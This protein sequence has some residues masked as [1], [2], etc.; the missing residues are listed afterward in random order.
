VDWDEPVDQE[1]H[2]KWHHIATDIQEVTTYVYPRPYFTQHTYPVT[3][4]QIH[5]FADASL[6]AYGAVA[7]L[8]H[9]DQPTIVMSR[10][11][12]APVKSITLPK[13]E[14]MAAVI[15]TRLTKF[16]I[17]SLHLTPDDTTVHLWSDSQITLHWIYNIKQTSTT[18]PFVSNRVTE[19]TQSFPASTWTYVP[20]D[21]N[22]ADLL[23]R[24]ISAQQL[25]SSQLWLHGPSWLTSADQWP[26]WS[27]ANVLHLQNTDVD[28]T[29]D[30][31]NRPNNP[32]ET[33][34][35]HLVIDATRHSRLTKLLSITVYVL[36]FGHNL[37]HPQGKLT[38]PITA[39]ELSDSRMIWIKTSQ[40]LEYFDEI[41]NLKSQSHKRT[42][43]VRQLRLF[44]DDREFLRCGGR[45]HNAP[46]SELAKFPYLLSPNH[47]ITKLIVYATHERIHHSGVSSTVTA[48]RQ[49]YWFPAIRVFV[50]KLL[51]RCVT[52]VRLTG[53]PYRLP[54]PP[55]LP[56]TRTEDPTP[57]SVCGVDFTGAMYV[58][59]GE[60]ERKVYI[61]LFTCATTR[62]VHLEV[63]LDMTVESFMLAFRKFVGRRSLPRT[64]MSDNASTYLAAA[65]ELQ[66]LL[67]ST[68][69][70][71]ALEGHGITWQFIP[72]RAPWH[73]GFWERL[74][75]IT[76]QAL[77]K[78][79]GRSFVTLQILE[80]IVV[81]VEAT[82]NDRPLTYVSSDVADVEP[83]TPAHLLY[84]KRMTTLPH[85]YDEDPDDPDYVVSESRMR[86]Q[87]TNHARLLQHFQTRWKREYLTSLREFHK[88]SGMNIQNVQIGDVVLIHDDGPRL[89]WRLGVIDSLI[90]GNDGFVRSA[91]VR[92]SNRVTSRPISRL[93]PLEISHPPTDHDNSK[94]D[95][96]TEPVIH[97][98]DSEISNRPRRE[99]A[100]KARTRLL[101]WTAQLSAPP[102]DVEN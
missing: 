101:E 15:A 32:T 11:R 96:L 58:R 35:I 76:K 53:K 51:R 43:L 34:G 90:Q 44:L 41:A 40:Q 36:R 81:E 71:E 97:N 73:G 29:Q 21:D 68:S 17:A 50:R 89:H 13:L 39:R 37:R 49:H 80:T 60:G 64:M 10:S 27:P 79:L 61:C 57:F 75:G 82:L 33:C 1:N 59:S 83:L 45:I 31:P 22:P 16:V 25:K 100:K 94:Q 78:T 12:V 77:K 87:L 8:Q 42:Q 23:T 4:R 63:V 20:T 95:S 54:D 28:D 85:S 48:L 62:A 88:T 98:N 19:I 30:I 55:P 47:H 74:V 102:E 2:D 5:V 56:K 3:S 65:D 93:Y 84:G 6:L 72:K 38:G 7:Y 92:T 46:I 66:Q 70:K 18:K 9:N 69:L 52:C 14:L 26:T 86:K 67:N 99:A 91:N 24:G